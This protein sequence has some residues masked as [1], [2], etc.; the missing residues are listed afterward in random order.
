MDNQPLKCPCCGSFETAGAPH[1]AV[2]CFACGTT[3][4]ESG[5][6]G[7]EIKDCG[8]SKHDDGRVYSREGVAPS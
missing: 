5:T 1:V 4:C 2:L 6:N 7:I 8:C 3:F